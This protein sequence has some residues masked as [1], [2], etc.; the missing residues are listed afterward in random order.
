MPFTINWLI[1]NE[2]VLSRY[3]GVVTADELY[4]CLTTAKAMIESSPRALVHILTD[5]GDITQGIP[6]GESIRIVRSL[7]AH[8]RAGWTITLREKSVVLRM[9]I[10]LGRSLLKARART[11]DTY[12]QAVAHLKQFDPLLNWSSLNQ[13]VVAAL[14]SELRS[15]HSAHLPG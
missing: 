12:D 7:G 14:P 13:R 6:L 11:F 15:G 4:V 10:A 8:P 2:I 5:V 1:E 9:G 3:Y